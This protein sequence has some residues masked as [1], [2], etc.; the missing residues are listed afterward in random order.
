MIQNSAEYLK[1]IAREIIKENDNLDEYHPIIL[2][3][4]ERGY[5]SFISALKSRG[6][7]FNDVMLKAGYKPFNYYDKKIG[8]AYQLNQYNGK[9]K[10]EYKQ[11]M[12]S[13]AS[14]ILTEIIE[15]I[16]IEYD[17][18]S[19]FNPTKSELKS[20]GYND[21]LNAIYHR[22]L[23]INSIRKKA[24][25]PIIDSIECA[26][27]GTKTQSILEQF[28][29]KHT[30]SMG[31]ISFSEVRPNINSNIKEYKYRVIDNLLFVDENCLNLSSKLRNELE[32]RPKIKLINIDYFLGD[33]DKYI[34]QHCL[35]GY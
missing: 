29:L 10:D 34:R 26:S 3:L 2:D 22:E 21:F 14:V 19:D 23:D 1:S 13:N 5:G 4:Q 6:L 9:K 8:S 20:Y 33:S 25:Y 12:I 32:K 24:G 7:S 15:D 16:I 35:R 17:L 28:F 31:C 11:R 30:R 18:P 27:L